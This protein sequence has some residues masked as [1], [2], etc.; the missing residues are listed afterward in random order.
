MKKKKREKTKMNGIE[1]ADDD[2]FKY[3][4]KTK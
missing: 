2:I 4:T 3:Y 1:L